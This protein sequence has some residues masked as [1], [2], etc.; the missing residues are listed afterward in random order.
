MATS[1]EQLADPRAL[2]DAC[3]VALVG[4]N[5]RAEITFVSHSAEALLGRAAAEAVGSPLPDLTPDQHDDLRLACGRARDSAAPVDWTG[6]RPA[7]R[8]GL[9]RWR[10]APVAGP[11]GADG[12]LLAA[13]AAPGG[14]WP[15]QTLVEHFPDFLL[16]VTRDTTVRYINR[17]TPPV[18]PDEVVGR[19][20]VD[21][22]LPEYRAQVLDYH[23]RAWDTGEGIEFEVPL[24]TRGQTIWF[25]ARVAPVRHDGRT[26]F[27]MTVARDITGRRA[28][29]ERLQEARRME[30]LGILA[31]GIAHDF[32]N[33]LTGIIG[34]AALARQGAPPEAPL[35]THLQEVEKLCL[36]AAD[37]CRQMLAYAGKARLNLGPLDLNEFLDES[38]PLLRLSVPRH[39]AID[40]RPATGPT[41]V[42]AD[43]VSVWQAL[44]HLVVNAAEAIGDAEGTITIATGPAVLNQAFLER[45]APGRGLPEGEYVRLE[46]HD[47]GGGMTAEV[48]ARIF[49][50]FFTTKVAGR[51]LGLSAVQGTIHAHHGLIAVESTP[52]AGT[53]ATIYFPRAGAGAEP[54]G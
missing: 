45:H 4:L 51:G 34:H 37:R 38:G 25:Y 53:V 48:C 28:L 5:E 27:L 35:H 9:V 43:T 13:E 15:W 14:D 21:Y 10:I 19:R 20:A 7:S 47:N 30:S 40:Y 17:T 42:H 31:G 52:G 29:Q 50:P 23:A 26:E 11:A 39:I 24:R 1:R 22:V 8:G 32:N 6:P 44:Q 36:R 12:Y 2:L 3:P 46:V 33:L 18:R 49:E 41:L 54:P 16:L